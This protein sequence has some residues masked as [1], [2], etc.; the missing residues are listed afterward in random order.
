MPPPDWL[1]T[2]GED[3]VIFSAGILYSVLP[4][5]GTGDAETKEIITLASSNPAR[6]LSE[7][8]AFNNTNSRYTIKVT[9]YSEDDIDRLLTQ[10]TAGNTPD[11]FHY[12][13]GDLFTRELSSSK[14]GAAG[15]L[16]DLYRFLD[17]DKELDRLSFQANILDAAAEGDRLYELPYRFW[18]DTVAGSASV[19]G[20]EAGRTFDEMRAKLED[21][22]F[23]GYLFGPGLIREIVLELALF[24]NMSEY[25]DWS[26]GV[27]RFDSAEFR[28]LLEF[29]RLYAPESNNANTENELY[30]IKNGNQLL[31][32]QKVGAKNFLQV[33]DFFFGDSVFIGF[34]TSAGVGNSIVYDGSFSVSSAT[35]N[36]EAAWSFIRE[37]YTPEHYEAEGFFV[38]PINADALEIYCGIVEEGGKIG[39]GAEWEDG[40]TIEFGD[41][42]ENDV[43][44]IRELI[45]SLDRVYRVDS[46][47]FDIVW[48]DAQPFF[49]GDKSV[50]E[51]TAIIQSRI[52]LYVSEQR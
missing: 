17:S 23:R 5:T 42:T 50:D 20:P 15:Y 22:S 36:A 6:I 35:K 52:K 24:Y 3:F 13:M 32:R 25:I 43:R 49:C 29:V 34:P 41:T 12:S 2:T 26:S 47:V 28:E 11:I 18:I 14:L 30:S 19:L 46:T 7:I 33:F 37:F 1:I 31:M 16:T 48:E 51:V 44:R 8:L 9:E 4:D 40:F 21:L 10:M 38:V 45:A 27:C 39:A